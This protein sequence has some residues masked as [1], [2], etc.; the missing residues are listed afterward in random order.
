VGEVFTPETHLVACSIDPV[1]DFFNNIIF[2]NVNNFWFYDNIM[3]FVKN[4]Y[5]LSLLSKLKIF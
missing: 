3:M 4:V 2:P 1:M 5:I